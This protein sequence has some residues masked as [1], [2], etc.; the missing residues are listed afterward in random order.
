MKTLI[1]GAF[2]SVGYKA[3]LTL[4]F[5][6]AVSVLASVPAHADRD[7][8]H[9]DRDRDGWHG[10]RDGWRGDRD[11]RGHGGWRGGRG[12]YGGG[13]YAPPPQPY[14]YAQPV[15]VPPPVYAAPMPS[16]GISLFLPLNL[17]F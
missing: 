4:F 12:G 7:G 8:W 11:G 10:D 5:V 1:P 16:P 6:L 3:L 2:S 9:G 15:Y 13:G 14:N 17:R